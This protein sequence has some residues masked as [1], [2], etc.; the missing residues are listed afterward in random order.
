VPEVVEARQ[1]E[2]GIL[3]PDCWLPRWQS[4]CVR[5]VAALARAAGREAA[6]GAVR[7]RGGGAVQQQE[8][9]RRLAKGLMEVGFAVLVGG[10]VAIRPSPQ[11]RAPIGRIHLLPCRLLALHPPLDL[12][13]KR[14]PSTATNQTHAQSQTPSTPFLPND[15]TATN[16]FPRQVLTGMLHLAV[17]TVCDVRTQQE[18][19]EGPEQQPAAAAPAAGAAG[20]WDRTAQMAITLLRVGGRLGLAGRVGAR[21]LV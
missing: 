2:L 8:R 18:R 11:S 3:G 12:P 5:T 6:P 17:V 7:L 20:A 21:R 4:G 9:A 19:S 15:Q 13:N 16:R 10:V 1:R 14:S